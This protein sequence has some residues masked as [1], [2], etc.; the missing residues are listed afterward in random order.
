MHVYKRWI[1]VLLVAVFASG[2]AKASGDD[3]IR[4]A[5][6]GGIG[7]WW[8]VA[9]GASIAAPG[10]PG[11]ALSG[12]HD[13]CLAVG[14]VIQ[15]DGSTTDHVVVNRWSDA[16][17]GEQIEWDQ[18]GKAASLALSQWRFVPKP[19]AVARATFTVANF[20]FTGR[21][22]PVD[23][24]R[25][26]CKVDDVLDAVVV[27]RHEAYERGNL[28]REWLDRAYRETMRREIRANQ[29]NRCRTSHSMTPNCLD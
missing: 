25:N 17:A 23:E 3:D 20:A 8:Q 24:L 21:G 11:D 18:F 19:G 27:A 6:E 16:G 28:N 13:V 22:T 1:E 2:L 4:V 26:H 10:Y 14:Y 7:A 29:A 12:K 15:A 9:D 5:N